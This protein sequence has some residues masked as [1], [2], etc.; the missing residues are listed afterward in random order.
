M[1]KWMCYI[2][3]VRQTNYVIRTKLNNM[4]KAVAERCNNGIQSSTTDSKIDGHQN[5]SKFTAMQHNQ[6]PMVYSR[7][8]LK[9]SLTGHLHHCNWEDKFPVFVFTLAGGVHLSGHGHA[10]C[11][12]Q[13]SEWTACRH[14]TEQDYWDWDH[15]ASP[16]S[17]KISASQPM[18]PAQTYVCDEIILVHGPC[19]C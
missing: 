6:H 11:T 2:V 4:H 18:Q 19:A 9:Q 13:A 5:T 16:A 7:T 12:L 3:H 14:Q 1:L 10:S 17:C 15:S 8:W